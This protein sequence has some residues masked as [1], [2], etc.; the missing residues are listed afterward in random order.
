MAEAKIEVGKAAPRF[1]LKA[2]DG[3]KVALRDLAGKWVVLYFYPR[4]NT[5]GCTKEAIEFTRLLP[6]FEKR[7][8]VVY[9]CSPD[10]LESHCRFVEK[11]GL[12]V[13]L[14][15]DPD[16]RV[17]EKYGAWGLRKR[18]GKESEGTIRSTV[19][20]DPRGRI[21][22]HWRN[23]RAAGHAEKVLAKLDELLSA[24]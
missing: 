23:V 19:L 6:E 2:H 1:T 21:A 10:S 14:L 11:H 20:I 22:W 4:D 8:A 9:G 5:S 13:P 7:G 3:S 18:Y 17:M 16:H 15:S 12:G 24:G